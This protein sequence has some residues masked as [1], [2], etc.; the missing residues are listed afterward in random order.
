MSMDSTLCNLPNNIPDL[1]LSFSPFL[2]FSFS[3]CDYPFCLHDTDLDNRT[4]HSHRLATCWLAD[5]SNP[6]ECSEWSVE[7]AMFTGVKLNVDP[8]S[9]AGLAVSLFTSDII[10][11]NDGPSKMLIDNWMTE[12]RPH[13]NDVSNTQPG[14][15]L[16]VVFTLPT[17]L[18][19]RA[20]SI[21]LYNSMLTRITTHSFGWVDGASITFCI[22]S[23]S[24]NPWVSQ[25]N[26][27]E[28]YSL[29]CFP[30]T[31]TNNHPDMDFFNAPMPS[32]AT[33]ASRP[34]LYGS[35]HATLQWSHA[36]KST[37]AVKRS[38]QPS[39]L[40]CLILPKEICAIITSEDRPASSNPTGM[41]KFSLISKVSEFFFLQSFILVCCMPTLVKM[42][43]TSVY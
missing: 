37:M 9:E 4:C 28:L 43:C 26:S 22:H 1:P 3:A 42:K 11:L 25:P 27:I 39:S 12:E 20:R 19:I 8:K 15:C 38:L 33:S 14:H 41:L 21:T 18:V 5:S 29:S 34:L 2:I 24:D 30:L 35:T 10:T 36:G 32:S 17:I 23:H 40:V 7:D 16:Q 13:L 6:E 31:L